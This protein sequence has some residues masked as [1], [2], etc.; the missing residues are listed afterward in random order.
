MLTMRSSPE[1]FTVF[2]TSH[3]VDSGRLS[4]EN[5]TEISAHGDP[6]AQLTHASGSESF[7]HEPDRR[8]R[9][10]SSF[11]ANKTTTQNVGPLPDPARGMC[12]N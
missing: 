11:S 3:T 7:L 10:L 1:L 8:T 9:F 4:P 2:R 6:F 12:S 5:K